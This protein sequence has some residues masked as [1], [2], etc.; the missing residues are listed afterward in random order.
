MTLCS[1]LAVSLVALAAPPAPSAP[2]API[3]EATAEAAFPE[4]T[5]HSVNATA[6]PDKLR[7]GEEFVLTV[8]L[9]DA[10]DVRYELPSDLSLGKE[11]DVVRTS[12]SRAEKDGE[13]ETRFEI[14][15]LLFDLGERTLADLTLRASAPGGERRLV[16]P[17]PKVTG[18][19]DLQ[20][21]SR[22]EMHDIMP[23]VPVRVPRYTALYVAA[24]VL[25]A[26][27]LGLFL[28]R[29]IRSRPRR[30]REAPAPPPVPAH[31]R[32]LKALEDLQREDLPGQSRQKEFYF[33]VSEIL[34]DY[35]GE[36]FGVA[37]LDMTTEEL[38]AALSRVPTPGLDFPRFEA[39]CRE[40]DLVRFAR[41]QATATTCKASVEEAFAFVRATVPPEPLSRETRATSAAPVAP[42][43]G[44][45]A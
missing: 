10:K 33:R 45:A 5:P 34:R 20:A 26:A 17:L 24:G 40:G 37:A 39:F 27:L 2:S 11:F 22:E 9:R 14:R 21:D 16:V 42:S 4:A 8:T 19:G 35:L 36:R 18:A 12:A 43:K 31:V 32:A 3:G 30:V 44:A 13:L 7:L 23:P 25:S 15:A 28:A 1:A 41:A 38:L 6:Y 29:W